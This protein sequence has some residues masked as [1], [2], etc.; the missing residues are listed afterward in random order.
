[1]L[2]V[3]DL[4]QKLHFSMRSGNYLSFLDLSGVYTFP[5]KPPREEVM[6]FH[7]EPSS[8]KAWELSIPLQ[9][10][11]RYTFPLLQECLLQQVIHLEGN[12]SSQI[13]PFNPLPAQGW[14]LIVKPKGGAPKQGWMQRLLGLGLLPAK[15]AQLLPVTSILVFVIH[16]RRSMGSCIKGTVT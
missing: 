16:G 6:V 8:I 11:E 15:L 1:M 5:F 9:L 3:L 10:T 7:A 14:L 2:L 13:N 4:F 12:L